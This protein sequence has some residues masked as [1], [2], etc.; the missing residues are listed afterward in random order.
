MNDKILEYHKIQEHKERVEHQNTLLA[1][2]SILKT[3]EG[4][5]IV[6]YLFKNFEVGNLPDRSFEGNILHEY[7]GF[8]RAGN[9]IFKL[10]S[11]ADFEV[12]SQ[13]LAKIE[14]ERY[15]DKLHLHRLEH[16]LTDTSSD[17]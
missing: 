14:R 11:E 12:S 13:I 9:S 2:G 7:L 8:L 17:D 1:L 5:Q 4:Q 10:V 16:E 15:E 3:K 6:K